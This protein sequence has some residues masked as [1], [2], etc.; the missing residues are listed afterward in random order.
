MNE[1]MNVLSALYKKKDAIQL[2]KTPGILFKS[3]ASSFIKSQEMWDQR[4]TFNC[5]QG[6]T[7]YDCKIQSL[8]KIHL[9]LDPSSQNAS[10][11]QITA[12]HNHEERAV[13]LPE[14]HCKLH[15]GRLMLS[16]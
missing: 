9:L 8:I 4:N 6:I 14:I 15:S 10:A 7:L 13:G 11:Y 5:S 3:D 1:H 16:H 12:Y 2:D